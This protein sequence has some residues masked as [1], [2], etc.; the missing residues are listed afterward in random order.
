M[1]LRL[2]AEI[3]SG[4]CPCYAPGVLGQ[5]R[6]AKEV[7]VADLKTQSPPRA[8]TPGRTVRANRTKAIARYGHDEPVASF[9]FSGWVRHSRW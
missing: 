8:I 6:G 9:E 5:N 1:R 2:T 3:G 4:D 7:R